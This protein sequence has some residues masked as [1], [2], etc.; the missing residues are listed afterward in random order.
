MAVTAALAVVELLENI[1]VNLDFQDLLAARAVSQ[2][3][4]SVTSQ[5]LALRKIL[6]SAPISDVLGEIDMVVSSLHDTYAIA[7]TPQP[8]NVHP[9]SLPTSILNRQ[10]SRDTNSAMG[11]VIRVP[12]QPI[13]GSAQGSH[14]YVFKWLVEAMRRVPKGE[15]CKSMYLTQPPCTAVEIYIRPPPSYPALTPTFNSATLRVQNG[16]RLGMVVATAED[17]LRHL[18]VQQGTSEHQKLLEPKHRQV[19]R[20]EGRKGPR[21]SFLESPSALATFE[22]LEGIL[23]QLGFNDL[24]AARCVSSEWRS[25]MEQSLQIKEMMF[26]AALRG[27]L[28]DLDTAETDKEETDEEERKP[29]HLIREEAAVVVLPLFHER[30]STKDYY[31]TCTADTEGLMRS[32]QVVNAPSGELIYSCSWKFKSMKAMD[33]QL[34]R[35]MLLTQ[36]ACTA[37]RLDILADEWCGKGL[38]LDHSA[39]LRVLGGIRPGDI[40]D[41]VAAIM[42][43]TPGGASDDDDDKL[44]AEMQFLVQKALKEPSV[45][46]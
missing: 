37:L 29:L 28:L 27:Q 40:V 31:N 23:V 13:N 9:L 4:R 17:M 38:L 2:R 35:S 11:S 34:W 15:F 16:I 46:G 43:G 19:E 18:E 5:S 14:I 20:I 25:V 36:P 26:C 22:L 21:S 41:T 39:T 1:L 10:G 12:L 45:S 30:D 6:F 33:S 8:Y 3:W 42:K 44:Q 32:M 24:L 7:L